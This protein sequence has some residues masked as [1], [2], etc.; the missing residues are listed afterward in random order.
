M[1]KPFYTIDWAKGTNI[2]E[3]NIRQYTEEGTFK[4]FRKHLPRLADMGVEVLWLMPITP[5][6]KKNRLGT[7]G[8]YYACSS[9]V[10]INPEFGNLADFKELVDEAHLLGFK[11]IIDWVANHT[12]CDHEWTETN[13]EYYVR[14]A[15][16]GF[17]ERNG[18]EDVIDLDYSNQEM[19]A[20]MINAMRFWVREFGIDGFRCDMAHLVPLDFWVTARTSCE[21]IKQL[22]WLAECDEP[23]YHHV[24]D[25]SY[26]WQWMHATEKFSKGEVRIS[27]L[28]NVLH[29]YSQ[30]PFEALKLYFTSNH[31]ENSWNGT[32]YE[33]YGN[34]AKPLAVFN[35]TWGN[36]VPLIYSGQE[37]PNKK[38]LAFFNKDQIDWSGTIELHNFYK[39]LLAL[40]KINC[41][42]KGETFILPSSHNGIL[43]FMRKYEKEVA[44]VVINLSGN[45]KLNLSVQHQWLAGT[46]VNAFSGLE[47]QFKENEHFE[48]MAFEY[49]VYTKVEN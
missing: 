6:S 39:G 37:L 19:R 31:D 4:A 24:Y 47:Y 30:Y 21:T 12:G 14:D 44:L 33:K 9:Y 15:Q 48:I 10:G 38:R 25:V 26:A 34:A 8:S 43:A 18:W 42:A 17:T 49:L 36:G 3:V 1:S 45:S 7:L 22:F 23:S 20:A 11:I 13:P 16:G 28:Y 27:D 29:N 41:I 32:E 46:F 2:Y 35:A 5:I 40:H